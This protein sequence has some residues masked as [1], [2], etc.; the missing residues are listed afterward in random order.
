MLAFQNTGREWVRD[1]SGLCFRELGWH[2][3]W[4]GELDKGEKCKGLGWDGLLF[5]EWLGG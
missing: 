2:K 1:G 4:G 3:D 5:E